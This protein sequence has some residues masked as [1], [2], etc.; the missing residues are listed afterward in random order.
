MNKFS[1]FLLK[2]ILI[3]ICI[4]IFKI[5]A[6]TYRIKEINAYKITPYQGKE[7]NYIYGFYHSQLLAHIYFYRNTKMV[8]LASLHRD[9]EIAAIVAQKFGITIVRG[10]STRGGVEALLGLKKYINEGYDAALTVDGPRGPAG[11]VNN[12]VIYLAKLTGREIIPCCF[13]CD[14]NIRLKSWDRFM[15]PLPFSK[16]VFNFGRPIKIPEDLKEKD[17][18]FY[19]EKIQKELNRINKEAEEKVKK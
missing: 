18:D 12:G 4:F 3:P 5:I 6:S 1:E 13:A 7:R 2:K 17:I 11:K 9:G 16:G 15:I 19:R 8:S 10:S 14:R